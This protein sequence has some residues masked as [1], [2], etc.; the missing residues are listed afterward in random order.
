MIDK[1]MIVWALAVLH[2]N[3]PPTAIEDS[4][5]LYKG[6]HS[7]FYKREEATHQA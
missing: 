6:L 7:S 1:Q 4:V 3:S 2:V 5:G